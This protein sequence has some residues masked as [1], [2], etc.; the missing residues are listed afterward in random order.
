MTQNQTNPKVD[1]YLGKAGA[2][3]GEMEQLRKIILPF[4]LTE[5]LKWSKPCYAFEGKNLLIIIPFKE[6]CALMFCQG[7]LLQDARGVL[8]RPGEHTQAGRWIK[9]TSVGEIA[10]MA[11]V[12]RAYI[13][14]AIAAEQ[15][16]LKVRFK[17]PAAFNLPE[18]LKKKFAASPAL[19]TAF[20]A[21]TPGRQRAYCL[22]FSGAKQSTT[23]E[24]RIEKCAPQI[25][26]GIG[27]N[28]ENRVRASRRK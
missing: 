12:L 24:A 19:K 1:A 21:L 26:Q 9:F 13:R 14:E 18:E 20:A 11:P 7:A 8:S 15:A 22:Y 25:L 16:G 5:E 27:W 2:W 28:E 3:R 6:S 4:P 17:P 10:K 23:R